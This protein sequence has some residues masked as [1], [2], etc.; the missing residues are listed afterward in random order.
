MAPCWVQA[1]VSQ[2]LA[3]HLPG[4]QQCFVDTALANEIEIFKKVL[5]NP[6]P[7]VFV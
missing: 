7:A 2:G 6:V 5:I 3:C 1:G 4:A